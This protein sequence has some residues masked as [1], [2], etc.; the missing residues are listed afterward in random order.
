MRRYWNRQINTDGFLLIE[1]WQ[2]RTG[3][4]TTA[5]VHTGWTLDRVYIL[6]HAFQRGFGYRTV[7]SLYSR[8]PRRVRRLLWWLADGWLPACLRPCDMRCKRQ[9]LKWY[10]DGRA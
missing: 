8:S 9:W 7:R 10:H 3:W 4:E 1:S 2:W 5:R 6:G